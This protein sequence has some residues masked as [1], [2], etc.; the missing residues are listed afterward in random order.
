ML[1]LTPLFAEVDW[2]K[3]VIVGGGILLYL[4]SQLASMF[5]DSDAT[6][7]REVS[8]AD[9]D[10]IEGFVN[11]V[12]SN[13]QLEQATYAAPVSATLVDNTDDIRQRHLKSSFVDQADERMESHLH[14]A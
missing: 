8:P 6:A 9:R 13:Q 5:G 4:A 12:N 14:D 10:D 7:S 11:Q 3:L 2:V 1:E